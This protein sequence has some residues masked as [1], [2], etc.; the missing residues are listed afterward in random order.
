MKLTISKAIAILAAAVI[1]TL[2][3][4]DRASASCR[5]KMVM[6]NG[7]MVYLCCDSNG[8]CAYYNEIQFMC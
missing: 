3:L 6:S 4:A 5:C 8:M 2:M 1:P 7:N